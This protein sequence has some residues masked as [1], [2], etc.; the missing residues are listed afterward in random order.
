M[1][2]LQQ[3]RRITMRRGRAF[4][5]LGKGGAVFAMFSNPVFRNCVFD[6]NYADFG[7]GAVS[8]GYG[9]LTVEDC[10]FTGNRTDGLGAAVQVSNSPTT[11]TGCT[12]WAS[13]GAALHYASGAITIENC[14]IAEGDAES[15]LRNNAGD[16]D[17]VMNCNNFW[18]NLVDYGEFIA[19]QLG[20]HGNISEDPLFCNPLF[21]Q[22]TLY[23]VSPCAAENAGD[24][25]QIGYYGVGCGTGSATYVIRPDGTGAL[26]TIQAALNMAAT[27]DTIALADGTFTGDGNR[28]LDF[29]GKAVTLLGQ[30]GDPELA[31]ID[32]GGSLAQPHRAFVFQNGENVTS[33]VQDIG[34]TNGNV[35]GDGGAIWCAS[36]P[37]IRN[38][39]FWDNHAARGGAIFCDGG[40][41]RI[42][43]CVFTGNEGRERA[44]G[45]GF[46]GSRAEV[47]DCF[48]SANWGYMGAAFFLPDS[49]QVTISGCTLVG[50]ANAN[51]RATIG[52]NGNSTVSISDCIVTGGNHHAFGEYDEGSVSISGCNLWGNGSNYSGPVAGQNGSNGNISA[53]PLFCDPDGGDYTLRADSPCTAL[54]APNGTRMGNQPVGC[55]APSLFTDMSSRLPAQNRL[56]VGVSVADWNDDGHPDL[57]FLN[58]DD[59]NEALLGDGA[60]NFTPHAPD[61][62]CWPNHARGA[63][64]M[65]W[66][67]DGDLDVYL[68]LEG[69]P[70]RLGLNDGGAFSVTEADSLQ[71][72]GPDATSRWGDHNGDGLPDLLIAAPDGSTVLMTGEQDGGYHDSTTGDLATTGAVVSATFCDYDNDGDQDLFLVQDG[73]PDRLLEQDGGWVQVAEDVIG[74]AGAGQANSGRGA[75]WGDHDN[76]G[77]MDLFLAVSDGGNRLY[78][79]N[80]NDAFTV[81]TAGPLDDAGPSRSGIWGDWDNDGDLDLFV[82]NCGAADHL[83]RNDGGIFHDTADSVFAAADS[84]EGAAFTDLDG[85][86]DL[87]LVCAVRGA[88]NRILRNDNNNG[89]H[90]LKLDLRSLQGRYQ[91]PGARVTVYTDGSHRQIREVG[92]GGGWRSHD[93]PVIHFGLGARTAVDSVKVSWPGGVPL[94]ARQVAAD[95]LLVMVEQEEGEDPSAVAFDLKPFRLE[96]AFPNP[97][98]PATTIAYS[99]PLSGPVRL[100]VYDMAGRHVRTLV[101]GPKEAGRHQAV[102]RGRDDWGRAVAAGVYCTRLRAGRHVATQALTL[103]K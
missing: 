24:C 20:Q 52:L 29:L 85:D 70:N 97:F 98:N 9:Q 3:R 69:L 58:E 7:G 21:G 94:T 11:I 82:T 32:C 22:L 50:N 34:I 81:L 90:W 36:S 76:D 18:G 10:V 27:G 1:H 79:N 68:D 77:D 51:D 46:L 6:S 25:G 2:D 41:P 54:N 4:S 55:A 31:I 43:G 101:D 19:G 88:G 71:Q 60:W 93:D 63:A 16:P 17:P 74:Q 23:A 102:W 12:I 87:D 92:G 56:S 59:Q 80:G 62:L 64:F 14:L 33:V 26:P 30:S 95:Q 53:D 13:R 91:S 99:V 72:E 84:T 67:A 89:H 78:R 57:L 8:A 47:S 45:I 38:V 49:S 65:D 39:R 86:G 37:L 83:L 66:D 61:I 35:G 40:S 96:P 44:G 42:R 5:P 73:Q 48:L 100:E 15:L 103:L 28:D 75:A